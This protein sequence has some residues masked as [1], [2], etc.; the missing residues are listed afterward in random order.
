MTMSTEPP[1]AAGTGTVT[2]TEVVLPGVVEPSGLQLRQRTL[3]PPAAGQVM[4]RVEAAGVSFAEQGMRRNRYPGQPGFPFVPGYDLIGVVTATGPDVDPAW[5]GQRVAALTKT[6]GWATFA[7]VPAVTLV[8]VPAGVD[9]ADAETVVVNG[10][11][12]WQMLHR[13]ARIQPGQT[14]LVHGANGGVGTTLVQ[15]ARH[16]GVR[17]IGTASP[18]HHDRLRALGA[19]PVDYHDPDLAGRVRALAPDGVDAVFDHL[20]LDSARR[21]YRLLARGGTLVC[22]GTAAQRDSD[23]SMLRLFL[24]MVTQLAL[25]NYLPTGRRASFYNVWGGHRVNPARFWARLRSDLGQVLTLLRDG[26]LTAQVAARMPLT[27]ASAAMELAESHTV[28][29]KVILEP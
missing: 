20:G 21:S 14:V 17:V 7:L 6:G 13:S 19:E 10:V 24:P 8:E 29:G 23:T 5:T 26:V 12:A 22:Y 15:L 9:P 27:E 18:R 4:V 1:R 25:W 3:T 2:A 11:T 16:A 28:V